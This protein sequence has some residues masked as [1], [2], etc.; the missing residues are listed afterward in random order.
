MTWQ[1][2]RHPYEPVAGLVDGSKKMQ[3]GCLILLA[4][5]AAF[6]AVIIWHQAFVDDPQDSD[7]TSALTS[8][9]ISASA[10]ASTMRKL[11]STPVVG[12]TVRFVSIDG[13]AL[14]QEVS[15]VT[16][17]ESDLRLSSNAFNRLNST[18]GLFDEQSRDPDGCRVAQWH[19][20]GSASVEVVEGF[21]ISIYCGT[22]DALTAYVGD[23]VILCRSTLEE[24]NLAASDGIGVFQFCSNPVPKGPGDWIACESDVPSEN[25]RLEFRISATADDPGSSIADAAHTDIINGLVL[26]ACQSE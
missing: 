26:S 10:S 15:L 24:A 3:S 21:S 4:V 2:H 16:L 1:T 11:I 6:G 5:F 9:S 12:P 17:L 19:L 7:A 18:L 22:E 23:G 20:A 8:A 14:D 25:A 13:T